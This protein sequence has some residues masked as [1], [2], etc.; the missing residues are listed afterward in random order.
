M[1]RKTKLINTHKIDLYIYLWKKCKSR[2]GGKG[3]LEFCQQEK[4]RKQLLE[5]MKP[6]NELSLSGF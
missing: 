5:Y 4:L 6:R 3:L 2:G 1:Q